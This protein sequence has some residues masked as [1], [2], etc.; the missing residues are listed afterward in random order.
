MRSGG[1]DCEKGLGGAKVGSGELARKFAIDNTNVRSY[2][3]NVVAVDLAQEE[4]LIALA[5]QLDLLQIEFAREAAAYAAGRQYEVD[6]FT[7]AI[8]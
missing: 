5:H 6:G 2:N 7:T 1:R 4:K 3:M 8:G